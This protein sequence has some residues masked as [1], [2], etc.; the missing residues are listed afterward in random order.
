MKHS[1]VLRLFAILLALLAAATAGCRDA[2]AHAGLVRSEPP[3][4]VTLAA[5]PGEYHLW[6]NED[7][8]PSFSAVDVLDAHGASVPGAS[9]RPDPDAAGGLL[10]DLPTLSPGAYTL[11]WKTLS[12]TDG[13]PSQGMVLFGINAPAPSAAARS[14]TSAAVPWVEILLRWLNYASLAGVVGGLAVGL[15]LYRGRPAR[16]E[17]VRDGMWVQVERRVHG[18]AQWCAVAAL[19]VGCGLLLRQVANSLETTQAAGQ[20]GTLAEAWWGTGRL[21]L[22]QTRWGMLWLLREGILLAIVALLVTQRSPGALFQARR[23]RVV[24]LSAAGVSLLLVQ[25][26]MGHAAGDTAKAW[27]AVPATALH[28]LAASLWV[29]GLLALAIGWLPEILHAPGRRSE[30]LWTAFHPFGGLA[31]V[32]VMLLIATGLFNTGQ[33]VPS[34]DALVTTSYGQLLLGKVALLLV[35]GGIGLANHFLLQPGIPSPEAQAG[36]QVEQTGGVRAAFRRR[37]PALVAAELVVGAAVVLLTSAMTASAPPRGFEYTLAPEDETGSM[38]QTVGD[39]KMALDIKPNRPGPNV[40]SVQSASVEEPAPAPITRVLLQFTYLGADLGRV[41]VKAEEVGPGR[42]LL[43]GDYLKLAGPWRIDVVTRRHGVE[44]TVAHFNWVVM[45]LT[46]VPP[47]VLS[48]QPL[49]EPLTAAA[50]A[51]LCLLAAGL[52]AVRLRKRLVPLQGHGGTPIVPARPGDRRPPASFES[53]TQV[54]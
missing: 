3:D 42:Y 9:V 53:T 19:L 13:H 12:A 49:A 7:I 54:Q 50:A 2:H 48:K 25:A 31:A 33:Q 28:L 35:A 37:M 20:A 22:T 26:L 43:N 5:A 11:I 29:G 16:D 41:K 46:P 40:F 21:L 45:P 17:Q 10:V 1:R 4:G 27:Y 8:V 36:Q 39:V 34:L 18:V 38:T 44:D 51:V 23:W 52:L 30:L 47:T 24:V 6:F 14:T 15:Y 32:S